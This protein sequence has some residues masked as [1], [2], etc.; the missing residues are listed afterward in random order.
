[1]PTPLCPKTTDLQSAAVAD[2]LLSH[3]NDYQSLSTLVPCYLVVWVGDLFTVLSPLDSLDLNE[4]V[5]PRAGFEPATH[6]LK[7][8]CSTNWA[9]GAYCGGKPR[10]RPEHLGVADHCLTSW[11]V[12]HLAPEVGFKP[13]TYRLEGGYCCS[14]SYSGI[15]GDGRRC[16]SPCPSRNTLSFQDWF[17]GRRNS[18]ARLLVFLTGV[19]PATSTTSR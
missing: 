17:A 2:L 10:Y 18:S 5:V 9:T 6:R 7:V 19:E 4:G 16:R 13:T 15:F 11:L 1:M 14:L 3:I 12:Y 8:Y